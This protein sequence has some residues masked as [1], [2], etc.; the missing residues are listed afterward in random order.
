MA[1]MVIHLA[2][3]GVYKM[4]K[5]KLHSLQEAEEQERSRRLDEKLLVT[6][7]REF[8]L[9]TLETKCNHAGK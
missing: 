2:G 1:D 5:T 6:E 9:R 3:I 7:R 8:L 4:H